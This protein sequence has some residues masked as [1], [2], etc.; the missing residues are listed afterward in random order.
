MSLND[1]KRE[2]RS[3]PRVGVYRMVPSTTR[4]GWLETASIGR[5]NIRHSAA[6]ATDCPSSGDVNDAS[7]FAVLRRWL[8]SGTW[9][10]HDADMI[11]TFIAEQSGLM[12]VLRAKHADPTPPPYF[13]LIRGEDEPNT[14]TANLDAPSA[15]STMDVSAFR[16][17]VVFEWDGP[18]ATTATNR[19]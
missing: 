6:E 9:S 19:H 12:L 14:T 8:T 15:S 17:H 5:L 16:F 10:S 2:I 13:V 11:G 7:L 1:K 18:A 4:Q 3:A